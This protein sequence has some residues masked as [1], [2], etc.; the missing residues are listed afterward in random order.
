MVQR[1]LCPEFC[2]YR[3]RG[4]WVKGKGDVVTQVHLSCETKTPVTPTEVSSTILTE[5]LY[6]KKKV[7]EGKK[8]NYLRDDTMF[9]GLVISTFRE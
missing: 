4:P 6:I 2:G 5:G 1:I 8:E 3:G 9:P 7:K